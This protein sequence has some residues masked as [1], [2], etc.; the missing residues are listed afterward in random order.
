MNAMIGDRCIL[1]GRPTRKPGELL[2]L[3]HEIRGLI[4]LGAERMRERAR[5]GQ[6]RRILSNGIKR[7][8]I[9][10]SNSQPK[11]N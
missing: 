11:G 1:C 9:R 2:C 6:G 7:T 4:A 8:Q 5:L 3:F 10:Y